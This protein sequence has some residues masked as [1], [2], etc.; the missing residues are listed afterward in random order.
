MCR[1]FCWSATALLVPIAV[2]VAIALGAAPERAQAQNS[3][4]GLI[5]Q[6]AAENNGLH[7]AWYTRVSIDSSRSAIASIHQHVNSQK[8]FTVYE[9]PH[10][11]GTAWISERQV[12]RRGEMLGKEGARRLA[13]LETLRFKAMGWNPGVAKMQEIPETRLYVQ[14]NDGVVHALDGH[15]GRRLWTAPVGSRSLVNQPVAANNTHVAVTNGTTLYVLEADTG[16]TAWEKKLTNVPV[17][18]L[19]V[20]DEVVF[21]PMQHGLMKTY[22]IDSSDETLEESYHGSVGEIIAAPTISN[23]NVTW[24]TNR[25][26]LIASPLHTAR[27]FFWFEA[28]EE[29]VASTAFSYPNQIIAV[30]RDGFIL[31]IN[32]TTGRKTWRFSTGEPMSQRPIVVDGKVYAVTEAGGL[33]Q[34]SVISG[35]RLWQSQDIGRVLAVSQRR[36]Y[37]TDGLGQIVVLDVESGTKLGTMS[38]NGLDLTVSNWQTDRLFIGTRVGLI[39]CLHEPGQKWPLLHNPLHEQADDSDAEAID[40]P[41]DEEAEP[42][43]DLFGSDAEEDAPVDLDDGDIFDE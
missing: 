36:V 11:R 3:P 5:S 32:A 12:N 37:A 6:P 29:I 9:I 19:A 38:I 15:S 35:L 14:S 7:R 17:A 22:P 20:T 34:L 41:A 28:D 16:R 24:S 18:G 23:S 27:P 25:G 2:A 40:E 39:H 43:D 8:S 31:N 42:T 4:I 1:S 13:D 10:D 26:R 21:V 30:S 33:N